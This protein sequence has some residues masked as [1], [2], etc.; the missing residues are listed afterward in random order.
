MLYIL[1]GIISNRWYYVHQSPSLQSAH[2]IETTANFT[3]VTV[4]TGL[5]N[6]IPATLCYIQAIARQ[7][8]YRV[9]RLCSGQALSHATD[10]LLIMQQTTSPAVL[11]VHKPRLMFSENSAKSIVT[12]G[13]SK[14]YTLEILT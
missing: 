12:P 13:P 8:S 6:A 2:I 1:Y 5:E 9:R 11:T 4:T 7:L 10:A 14:L 3:S